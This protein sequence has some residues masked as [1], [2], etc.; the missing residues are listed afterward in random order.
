MHVKKEGD[1]FFVTLFF[2]YICN[3]V[4]KDTMASRAGKIVRNV[5]L[6]LAGVLVVA[7][8][9]VQVAL[10]DKVLTRIVNRIAAQFVDGSVK[11]DR[12]HASVFKSFPSLT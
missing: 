2:F 3:L 1:K 7:L 10:S 5:L 8:V 9:A 11:F 6:G 12:V 4:R